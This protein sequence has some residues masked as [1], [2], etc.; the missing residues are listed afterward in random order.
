MEEMKP[1]GQ[2]PILVY[3]KL[4]LRKLRKKKL[5]TSCGPSEAKTWSF[6]A[7]ME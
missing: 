6:C 1:V 5:K 4:S 3:E 2:T 7:E